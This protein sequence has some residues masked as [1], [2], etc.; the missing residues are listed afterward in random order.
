MPIPADSV[1]LQRLSRDDRSA[2]QLLFERHYPAVFQYLQTHSEG[3][4]TT[5]ARAQR[6]FLTLWEKRKELYRVES[7]EAWLLSLA[8]HLG[9]DP[10]TAGRGASPQRLPGLSPQV[11]E[12][13]QQHQQAGQSLASLAAE[14]NL[15]ESVL[16]VELTQGVMALRGLSGEPDRWDVLILKYLLDDINPQEDHALRHW[17]DES[18]AHEARFEAAYE[19]WERLADTLGWQQADVAGAWRALEGQLPPLPASPKRPWRLFVLL[20]SG[21]GLLA[22]LWAFWPANPAPISLEA[23]SVFTDESGTL[24][25]PP[26]S[27][28]ELFPGTE[29]VVTLQQGS[30]R[31]TA[32]AKTPWQ[33]EVGKLRVTMQT[34]SLRLSRDSLQV[35]VTQGT[36]WVDWQAERLQ[37][38]PGHHAWVEDGHLMRRLVHP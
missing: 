29:K 18:E 9:D 14:A 20:G 17:V 25:L 30:L 1:Y 24:H 31:L 23:G 11:R 5:E 32:S 34:G 16:A 28:A 8:R 4:A 6:V 22:V 15:S 35:W 36:A 37:L 12:W 2:L 21:L 33:L 38:A 13:L 10:A 3:Q 27:Q 7:L 26:G 19:A